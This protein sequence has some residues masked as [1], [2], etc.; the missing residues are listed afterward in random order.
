M[1]FLRSIP[2]DEATGT[3]KEMYEEDRASGGRLE[4][5]IELWSLRPEV[6]T[7]W[8]AMLDTIIA[9]MDRRR[10]LLVTLIAASRVKCSI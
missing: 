10:Y 6:F 1:P 2:P 3:L 5:V 9:P 4:S 7:A 8:N